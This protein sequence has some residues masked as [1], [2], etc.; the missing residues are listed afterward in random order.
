MFV[1]SIFARILH[2]LFAPK[3]KTKQEVDAI[4]QEHADA[5]QAKHG[6]SLNWQESIVDA[7]KALGLD[8]SFEAR[9]DLWN[10]FRL[11]GEFEG[12]A[13][14]NRRLIDELREQVALGDF[15]R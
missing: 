5:Y 13:A 12:S 8:P 15:A 9:R 2:R 7:M 14:Q 1:A 10:E 11:D 4:F 3:K 6:Q